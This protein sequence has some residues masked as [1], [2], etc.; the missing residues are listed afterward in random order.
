M[1]D[2]SLQRELVELTCDLIAYPSTADR[3]AD[4]AAIVDY[5]ERYARSIRGVFVQRFEVQQIPCLMVTLRPT[6][7][8]TVILNGHLDVVAARPEQYQPVIQNGRIYGRGSQDMKGAC[9]VLMRLMKDLAARPQPPDI[10]FM[11]VADEEIGGFQGTN[12]LLDQGWRSSLFIAAEPTDLNICYA[13]KGMVR[14]DIT[15]H[16]RP[17][18]G[19]RPWEGTNPIAALR[20]G[21]VALEQRFPTPRD[22]VWATTAVPTVVRGGETLNR[23]PEEVTLSLD[24]RHVPDETP[25]AI[26]TAVRA[27]FPGATVVRNSTGG[28]PLDTDPQHPYL[29]RLAACAERVTGRAPQLYREHFGSDARFYSGAGIPAICFGPVGAGLH[30]DDEW[31]ETASLEQL[32][33]ILLDSMVELATSGGA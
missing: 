11:F 25:E 19:S 33:A 10:G 9:A 24:I 17:A 15:I 8:P 22:A 32:Y 23:I 29:A 30:S 6:R 5:V 31:V 18:H 2:D 3:P 21:L 12:Y 7:T 4:L 14:L 13:A 16:G 20:D 1:T 26:E 28:I 27:C